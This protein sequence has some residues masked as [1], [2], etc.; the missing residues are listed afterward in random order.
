MIP[1][2][3]VLPKEF[4]WEPVNFADAGLCQRAELEA[5]E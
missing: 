1:I 3:A 5:Y 4:G 2:I